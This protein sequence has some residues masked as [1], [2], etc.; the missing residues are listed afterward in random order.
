MSHPTKGTTRM[1]PDFATLP[2]SV[3]ERVLDLDA[4]I[5]DARRLAWNA[6]QMGNAASFGRVDRILDA[7]YSERDGLAPAGGD[8][9]NAARLVAARRARGGLT[10]L[11][12]STAITSTA[13]RA[14]RCPR[15]SGSLGH[16]RRPDVPLSHPRRRR[17]GLLRRR[18]RRRRRHRRLS[19]GIRPPMG[20]YDARD[21]PPIAPE[22]R[23]RIPPNEPRDGRAAYR[24]GN[25]WVSIYG[26]A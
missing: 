13:A 2:T 8:L 21:R 6:S 26:Y 18:R 5:L 1:S 20:A 24:L 11:G 19:G 25:P 17:R 22:R 15:A 7:L 3:L 14:I 10:W 4:R 16:A 23:P 9:D 12:K